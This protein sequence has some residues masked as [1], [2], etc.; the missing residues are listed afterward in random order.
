MT[1][2][3]QTY[4]SSK[5]RWRATLQTGATNWSNTS[6]HHTSRL[7]LEHIKAVRWRQESWTSDWPITHR[8][9]TTSIS[10]QISCSN[11]QYLYYINNRPRQDPTTN[12]SLGP[13][14]FH[15]KAWMPTSQ[16]RS[17]EDRDGGCRPYSC[18]WS[19]AGVMCLQVK[20]CDPHLSTLGVTF[21][22]RGAKQIYVYLYL[23]FTYG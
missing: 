4:V 7:T 8:P 20:L 9:I 22:W 6:S 16:Q 1:S 2:W 11:K 13:R 12:S 17:Q 14:W 19:K 15:E 23:T 21:S 3:M 18:L 10:Q 5:R